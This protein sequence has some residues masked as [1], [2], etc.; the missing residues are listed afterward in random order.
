[1]TIRSV[2]ALAATLLATL[3]EP[4]AVGAETPATAVDIQ[5]FAF[6]PQEITVAPGTTITWTNKDQTAHSVI[7]RE[8][9]FA[10]KGMDTDDRYTFTF[11]AEGDYAYFCS[12]H[13]HMIGTIH[14]RAH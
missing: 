3:A 12:L 13:P 14:V 10:S 7:S 4:I 6:I 5:S 9:K 8:G 11:T 2:A 1:M